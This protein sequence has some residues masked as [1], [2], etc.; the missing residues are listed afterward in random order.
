[1]RLRKILYSALL[2]LVLAAMA[3]DYRDRGGWGYA[4]GFYNVEKIL[5]TYHD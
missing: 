5:D 2:R 4:I 3:C 1:M